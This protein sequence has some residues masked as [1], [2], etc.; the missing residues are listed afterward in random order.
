MLVPTSLIRKS[1]P[2]CERHSSSHVYKTTRAFQKRPLKISVTLT[3][4]QTIQTRLSHYL[5]TSSRTAP[6]HTHT[7]PQVTRSV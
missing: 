4:S 2:L 5:L 1:H 3:E 7:W 6:S